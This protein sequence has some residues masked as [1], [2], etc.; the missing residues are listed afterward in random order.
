[1]ATGNVVCRGG[2]ED[3]RICL[4]VLMKKA[5]HLNKGKEGLI[6]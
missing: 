3:E 5:A 6:A 1:M 4:A 2:L